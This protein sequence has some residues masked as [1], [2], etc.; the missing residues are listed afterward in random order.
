MSEEAKEKEVSKLVN[1][2]V[3]IEFDGDISLS[4]YK[5]LRRMKLAEKSDKVVIPPKSFILFDLA[6]FVSFCSSLILFV[7]V[8]FE[9]RY[10]LNTLQNLDENIY[11]IQNLLAAFC[12]FASLYFTIV[13][14]FEDAFYNIADNAGHMILV[15]SCFSFTA[16]IEVTEDPSLIVDATYDILRNDNDLLN[17]F[18]VEDELFDDYFIMSDFTY[19]FLL[20]FGFAKLWLSLVAVGWGVFIVLNMEVFEISL[21]KCIF[22]I[23]PKYIRAIRNTF[24][25][26]ILIGTI[27]GLGAFASI[28]AFTRERSELIIH[29]P[30]E[31]MSDVTT[32]LSDTDLVKIFHSKDFISYYTFFVT[33]ELYILGAIM[34]I[35]FDY[36]YKW[37][38]IP[39]IMATSQVLVILD[40]NDIDDW[41]F[42]T[43]FV[44]LFIQ[45]YVLISF[46][47][48][49][50]YYYY[51]HP[52]GLDRLFMPFPNTV[53]KTGICLTIISL[54]FVYAGYRFPWME[55]D[56]EPNFGLGERAEELIRE[57]D[58]FTDQL[59]DDM[60]DFAIMLN[61][62]LKKTD[63]YTVTFEDN[64]GNPVETIN[65][66]S[67]NGQ[68]S[69]LF[70]DERKRI[71]DDPAN[72]YFTCVAASDP[73]SHININDG[74]TCQDLYEEF[75][76][77]EKE[78]NDA[79]DRETQDLDRSY[80]ADLAEQDTGYFVNQKC[81]DIAC[82]VLLGVGIAAIAM[83]FV[84][85]VGGPIAMTMKITSKA[86]H[87]LFKIGKK[88]TRVMGKLRT[89]RKTIKRIRKVLS[90]LVV[91]GTTAM[92][93][94][95]SMALIF[96]PVVIGA[97]IAIILVIVRRKI[98]INPRLPELEQ[99]KQKISMAVRFIL[100]FWAPVLVAEVIVFF[101]LSFI[102]VMIQEMLDVIPD[103]MAR[104]TLYTFAGY[105]A[106]RICYF[107]AICG[108]LL[109]AA[110]N[111]IYIGYQ[112]VFAFLYAVWSVYKAIIIGIYRLIVPRKRIKVTRASVEYNST[113]TFFGNW[114]TKWLL[115][116]IISLPIFWFFINSLSDRS[117]KYV[118]F[119]YGPNAELVGSSKDL[120]DVTISNEQVEGVQESAESE[121][122]GVVGQAV[123]AFI[124]SINI[125][126]ISW[127]G[128]VVDMQRFK[129][130]INGA[131]SA[132][133]DTLEELSQ[134]LGIDKLAIAI[135]MFSSNFLENLFIFGLPVI[136]AGLTVA[137]WL[138]TFIGA[139]IEEGSILYS[140]L[141]RGYVKK[142][143]PDLVADDASIEATAE[144][145]VPFFVLFLAI[146][147]FIV[148]ETVMAVVD[149]IATGNIP[150]IQ[151][152]AE[153][154]T[155]FYQTQI[156]SLLNLLAVIALY[157][158][159]VFPDYYDEIREEEV[160]LEEELDKVDLNLRKLEERR[161]IKQQILAGE[162][163]PN[164]K[165]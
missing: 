57:V 15:A 156:C 153:P 104:G 164:I 132:A 9:M 79:N 18:D 60:R 22:R 106:L 26:R 24:V 109:L 16:L 20:A 151:I 108:H 70:Y 150:L 89:K 120:A 4:E 6:N 115:P 72:K 28:V 81:L 82:Y 8:V 50:A 83:S 116:M 43:N 101:F 142:Q 143:D 85:F 112:S 102:P 21:S 96:L 61:P 19:Y 75:T 88:L 46:L 141:V 100:G 157:V 124:A 158:N 58:D 93:F 25:N 138:V 139:K 59:Y 98:T 163:K 32:Y 64:D 92:A 91:R 107:V 35:V 39:G 66:V 147:N 45:V 12:C 53:Y 7:N 97:F 162:L 127:G 103:S 44:L 118:N 154:S 165:R 128:I 11:F 111:I 140:L 73:Y 47:T 68:Y 1:Q 55:I 152:G 69:D 52:K 121:S 2:D 27:I 84:P 31:S 49:E 63:D 144:I 10:E 51:L 113:V 134:L 131:L 114:N 67:T 94:T 105:D 90:K 37:A 159:M 5:K 135:V 29:H 160:I 74:G 161:K 17:Q 86:T 122:C 126:R 146:V 42:T 99:R 56:V 149:M 54:L 123:T 3:A 36:E 130:K 145:G 48:L 155:K 77:K 133:G 13:S 71:R 95:N 110:S 137:G 136:G 38:L 62:C 125:G 78:V 30:L 40:R 119:Y 34:L 41:M 33:W 23:S 80:N 14:P 117:L 148:H 76:E 129:D 87:T 65:S